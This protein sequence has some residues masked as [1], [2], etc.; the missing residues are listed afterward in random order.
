MCTYRERN[1]Q[2]KEGENEAGE[3][4]KQNIESVGK[5]KQMDIIYYKLIVRLK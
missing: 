5:I 1:S 3:T 2:R 4:T